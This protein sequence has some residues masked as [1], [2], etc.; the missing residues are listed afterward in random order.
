[1]AKLIYQGMQTYC[2]NSFRVY[3]KT[4]R[5]SIC[6]ECSDLD[7]LATT[8][9][10]III[11][12]HDLGRGIYNSYACAQCKRELTAKIPI[13][14]C[15][16]CQSNYSRVLNYLGRR[17]IL[18]G[19]VNFAYNNNSEHLYKLTRTGKHAAA[20]G[21]GGRQTSKCINGIPRADKMLLHTRPRHNSYQPI[22]H[23]M[24]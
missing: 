19:S 8:D 2:L 21:A 3:D 7:K 20:R 16:I 10:W 9:N 12:T 23:Y 15:H 1:M 14:L 6:L 17:N 18:P 22:S 5:R 11:N 24:L 4:A 13:R